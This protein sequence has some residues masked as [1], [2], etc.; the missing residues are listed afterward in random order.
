MRIALLADA[1]ANPPALDAVLADIDRQSDVAAI[2]HLGD[3][4]GYSS[5]PNE[6]VAPLRECG[7]AGIAGN[8]DSTVRS[9]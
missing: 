8:H 4:V 6:V 7:I 2:Y 9:V 1:D 5:Q 3:L